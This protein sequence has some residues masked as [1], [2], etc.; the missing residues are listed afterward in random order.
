[1]THGWLPLLVIFDDHHFGTSMPSGG[2]STPSVGGLKPID[3]GMTKS[4]FDMGNQSERQH[5]KR[6]VVPSQR[7]MP[8]FGRDRA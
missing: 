5:R 6:N 1:M 7:A 3:E 4:N 2:P 8:K